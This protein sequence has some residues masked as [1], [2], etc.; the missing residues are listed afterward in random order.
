MSN[1]LIDA[2]A[3]SMRP[4]SR[5]DVTEWCS[6]YVKLPHSARSPQFDISST[7]WLKEPMQVT[8]DNDNKEVVIVAPVGSGKTTLFEGLIPWIIS[9]EPGGTLV[10]LQTDS[11]ASTWA[12]TRLNPSLQLCEPIKNLFPED[13]HKKRKTEIIFPHMPLLIGGANLS[14]LQS[15]S[16]RWVI[17]DEVW[18]WKQGMIEEARRR[19]HDRW[20]SR[21]LFV[22]Q[23]SFEGDDFHEAYKQT[24]QRIFKWLC[25]KCNTRNAWNFK[26]LIYDETRDSNDRIIESE[27]EQTARLKCPEC[28]HEYKDNVATRRA[29]SDSSIYESTNP[30]AR[31]GYIGFNYSA[32]CVWWIPWGKLAVEYA[33]ANEAKKQGVLKP[34]S[35]FIQ[36]RLAEFWADEIGSNM[37]ALIAADYKKSEFVDGSLWDGEFYRFMTVDVQRDHFWAVIRA[38]KPDGSSRLIYE[39]KILTWESIREIQKQY[40]VQDAC[41]AIDS[42]YRTDEAYSRCGQ[43]GWT[44]LH[45]SGKD[46]FTHIVRKKHIKKLYSPFNYAVSSTGKRAR[47]CHWSNEKVKD[48][49]SLLRSGQGVS[50]EVPQDISENYLKQIDSEVKKDFVNTQD[51]SVKYRWVKIKKDNHIWDCET[52]NLLMAIMINIVVVPDA[53]ED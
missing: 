12:E 9:E 30:A 35:Q 26:Y 7:P 33:K 6:K 38:W 37:S 23:G 8:A 21:C 42:Q 14:T 29:L 19:T 53:I 48:I 2:F 31:T 39:N 51:K 4:P 10:A 45:G 11:E 25:S 17:G 27:I 32:L 46:H 52:M 20:N 34:L 43:F 1:I 47:Y 44:A 36:K 16:M 24:D 18:I 49:L 3:D 22:S 28:E 5:L 13:R 41:T 15:K 40:K 50:W